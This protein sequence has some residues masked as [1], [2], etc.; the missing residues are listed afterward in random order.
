MAA[1]V[2]DYKPKVI[3]NAKI[4]KK[5][6]E[7]SLELVKTDD[8]LKEIVKNKKQQYVVGFALE[9]HNEKEN[10]KQNFEESKV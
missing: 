8:I 1:A 2:A 9:T 4:K 7:L 10:A 3:S 6:S 5:E